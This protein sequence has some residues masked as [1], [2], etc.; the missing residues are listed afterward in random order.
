MQVSEDYSCTSGLAL[1]SMHMI[2]LSI[3]IGMDHTVRAIPADLW[4]DV[5]TQAAAK[6]DAGGY[7]D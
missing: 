4:P 5:E 7:T 2:A 6:V 1:G 3:F